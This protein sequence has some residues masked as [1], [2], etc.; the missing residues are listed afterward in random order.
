MKAPSY[1][2]LFDERQ[3]LLEVVVGLAREADDDVGRQGDVR[4]VLAQQRDAVEVALARVGAAHL[5]Q[6]A[7]GARLQRQVDVLAQ[8]AQLGVRADHVLLHVL[9]VR[10][11]VADPLDPVDRVDRAQQLGEGR[12]REAASGEVAPVGVD[13]LAQQRHLGDALG[14]HPLDVLDERLQ[15]PRDVAPAGRRDDAV[16]A[17]H[18]AADGDLHPALELAGALLGQVAGEALELEVA[19]RAERVAREELGQLVHLTG[20]EGDVDERELAEDLVLDRLRPA[21]ADA[22]HDVGALALAALGVAE[23][24]EELA[25][26]RLADRAGVE[27]DQVGDLGIGRLGVADRL[28][29]ALHALA[30][31]LVHL[32]AE[33]RDV[34]PL[35]RCQRVVISRTRRPATRGSRSP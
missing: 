10:A 29:H 24:G 19:L 7:R 18:V 9:R 1:L 33:G 31:V 2:D 14:G 21:A 35:H 22:D 4:H 26:G 27:E 15:R 17:L 32:T 23:V 28:E 13:V 30:V 6:H 11:R 34:V 16:R 12:A 20:A 5:L 3:R 8:R 25:V